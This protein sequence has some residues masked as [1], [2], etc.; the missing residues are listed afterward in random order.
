MEDE[1][2]FKPISRP[3]P[4]RSRDNVSYAN[5]IIQET[6]CPEPKY[7]PAW[8]LPPLGSPS[9][10]H[11]E[12]MHT[13]MTCVLNGRAAPGGR[14]AC[15]AD[16]AVLVTCWPHLHHRLPTHCSPAAR[17]S[18]FPRGGLCAL[19]LGFGPSHPAATRSPLT[20]FWSLLSVLVCALLT[21]SLFLLVLLYFSPQQTPSC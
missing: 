10:C 12:V 9:V 8:R 20:S 6:A 3:K 15:T 11:W 21:P 13:G 17:A 1:S 14:K 5:F 18:S 4:E 19:P 2:T 16:C 7:K